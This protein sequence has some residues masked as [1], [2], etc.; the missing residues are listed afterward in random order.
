MTWGLE[1]GQ[2]WGGSLDGPA[3]DYVTVLLQLLP[4][5]FAW[6]IKQDP[7]FLALLRGLSR[8]AAR[9]EGRAIDLIAEADPRTT[10][11]LLSDWERVYALPEK[12]GTPPATIEGRRAALH[13][14]MSA[15]SVGN[16][17][18]FLELAANLGFPDAQVHRMYEPFVCTSECTD[19]LYGVE[20]YWVNTFLLLPNDTNENDGT[21]RCLAN[22]YKQ[23]HEIAIFE[24]PEDWTAPE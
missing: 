22:A 24:P 17:P 18:F 3:Q 12:C 5:G 2:E 13:A 11:E 19:A 4:N 8:E 9:V 15:R 21:L 23:A 1:W 7:F 10:T 20:G 16:V 14:K 6:A